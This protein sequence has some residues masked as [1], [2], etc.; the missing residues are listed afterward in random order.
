MAE[1]IESFVT[2]LQ[3]E[4]VQAG[5]QAAEKI[6]SE[7]QAQAE[8]IVSQAEKKAEKLLTDAQQEAENTLARGKTALELASRDTVLHLREALSRAI[9]AVLMD[10]AK[11]KLDDAD[12][13]GKLMH[14]VVLQYAKAHSQHKAVR[15]NVSKDMQ[16]KLTR[17][18]LQQT[19]HKSD[20]LPIDLKSRLAKSGFE[21]SVDDATVEVTA[22]S[23]V[24][25]LQ[26]LVGPNLGEMLDHAIDKAGKR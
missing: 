3:Q 14:D 15:I 18:A 25:T 12:F 2:K 10:N 7:A 9:N 6:R 20:G 5:R 4:G 13:L 22:E 24:D 16:K 17:W 11:S 23:V 19:H 26:E 21:Y 1:S 8:E